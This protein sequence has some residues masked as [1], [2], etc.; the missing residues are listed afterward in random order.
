MTLRITCLSAHGADEI[1]VSFE[2]GDGEHTD[3]ESFVI[4][5]CDCADLRLCAGPCTTEQ[6]DA[7]AYASSLYSARRKG[8]ILLGYGRCSQ[9][10]L[11]RKLC[12]RGI[13]REIAEAAA[14]DLAK[15]GYLD[16]GADALAE[17]ER[18][19]AKRWGERRIA[20]SLREKGYDDESIRQ[21]LWA[22]EDRGVDFV[23]NCAALIRSRYSELPSDPKERQK[24]LA[25]LSRMGY[26]SSAIRDALRR[27]FS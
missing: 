11:S 25:S 7:V 13:E 16:D 9:R 4:S 21:A 3:R 17:A 6:Y 27:S 20:A 19:V 22:L 14:A 15:E 5:T 23:E 10:A 26:T 1:Q 12:A 18:G 2:I 24:I 8:L